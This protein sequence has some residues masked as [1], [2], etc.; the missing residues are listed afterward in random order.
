MV[1]G[2]SLISRWSIK[3]LYFYQSFQGYGVCNRIGTELGIGDMSVGSLLHYLVNVWLWTSQ[4][5]L[6]C[7]IV[8][9]QFL[10]G[11]MPSFIYVCVYLYSVNPPVYYLIWYVYFTDEKLVGR[12][13]LSQ[14]MGLIDEWTRPA[15]LLSWVPRSVFI[16]PCDVSF[17]QRS[18]F[19]WRML[20][21]GLCFKSPWSLL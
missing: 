19:L 16:Q 1:C 11:I 12:N 17:P 6:R 9:K 13:V 14:I 2:Y 21:T 5:F 10:H 4:N 3:D 7:K 20:F 18:C 8:G 15:I